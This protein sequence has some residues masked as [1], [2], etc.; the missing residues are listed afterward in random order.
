MYDCGDEVTIESALSL[1]KIPLVDKCEQIFIVPQTRRRAVNLQRNIWL[2]KTF[3]IRQK[4]RHKDGHVLYIH[5]LWALCLIL[6]PLLLS[7]GMVLDCNTG[8]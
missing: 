4:Q 8:M 7:A 1:Q 2:L 5:R 6:T 3:G